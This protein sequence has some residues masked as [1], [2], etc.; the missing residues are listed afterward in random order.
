MIFAIISTF[1]GTRDGGLTLELA[2]V[3]GTAFCIYLLSIKPKKERSARRVE[4]TCEILLTYSFIWMHCCESLE[5]PPYQYAVGWVGIA[6]ICLL[7]LISA[8]YMMTDIVEKLYFVLRFKKI[9]WV[10]RKE[11]TKRL[12]QLELENQKEAAAKPA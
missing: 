7:V 6:C 1:A 3:L 10:R 5:S 4:L 8:G 9:E 12:K 11:L 2:A